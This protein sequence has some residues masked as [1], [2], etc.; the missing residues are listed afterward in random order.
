MFAFRD[1]GDND[2]DDGLYIY[3]CVCVWIGAL[4]VRVRMT[5][6]L[7]CRKANNLIENLSK[8][9]ALFWQNQSKC[10]QVTGEYGNINKIQHRRSSNSRLNNPF[11]LTAQLI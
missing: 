9:F 3:M 5:L 8:F 4:C 2:D 7:L 6:M 10:L 11:T 1:D